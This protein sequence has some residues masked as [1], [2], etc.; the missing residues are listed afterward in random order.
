MISLSRII[1]LLVPSSL[2]VLIA[3]GKKELPCPLF[4]DHRYSSETDCWIGHPQ[5]DYADKNLTAAPLYTSEGSIPSTGP[6]WHL[7]S[8]TL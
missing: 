5:P 2:P 4:P 1:L 6:F 3:S 8:L 7:K